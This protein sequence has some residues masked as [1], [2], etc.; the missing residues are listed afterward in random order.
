MWGD[1][2][3]LPWVLPSPNIPTVDTAVVFPATVHVEGTEL[4]EGRGTTKPFE[5]N[6]APFIDPYDWAGELDKFGFPGVKFR[7]VLLSPDISKMGRPDLRRRPDPRHRPRGVYTRHRRHRNDQD[8][9]RHV[10]RQISNGSNRRTNTSST[11]TRSTS[12]AVRTRS[13]NRSRRCLICGYCRT[14]QG[15]LNESIPLVNRFL[16]Y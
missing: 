5:L 7:H 11:R 8:R 2:T 13:A 15:R 9:L 4:S 6:G 12:S 3:G 14:W 16:L 1:E 10:H